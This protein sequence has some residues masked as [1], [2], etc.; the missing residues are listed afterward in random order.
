M[1][2][3]ARAEALGKA[4]NDRALQESA[5]DRGKEL[6]DLKRIAD[7][8]KG[9]FKTLEA[10]PDDPAA[11]AA[12]GKFAALVKG[13][14]KR[15]LPL[16]SKGAEPAWKALADRE[17]APPT[18]AAAQAALGEAWL[19]QAEKETPT[20]KA[21][22]RVRAADWLSRALPGLTGLAKV[23]VEKKLA[24][25]GP[26]AFS[27]DRLLLDLGSGVRIEL[28][29]VKPDAFMRGGNL[30]PQANWEVDE[31][32]EHRVTRT[33]GYH[34]GKYEVTR[35]QFAAFVKAKAYKTDA[36]REG[37]SWGRGTNGEWSAV[38]GLTWQTPNFPQTD[39]H[40]V[41]CVSWNDAK[42]FC[43]W[44]SKKTGR[45]VR[46]PTE[47]EWEFACRAGT[48]T[49]WSFGDDE[50]RVSDYAWTYQNGEF[51]THPVGQKK[52]N[53]WGFFDL[54]GNVCEWCQD[55]AGPYGAEAVD[56][57]GP[58]SGTH[59]LLRGGRWDANP[60][61]SRSSTRG[62]DAPSAR[63]TYSGFRIALY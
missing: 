45:G 15:G 60:Y 53:P 4:A 41:I 10:K 51:Q 39:E 25:L 5:K 12:V 38:A 54:H 17:L 62:M 40:P 16:L 20:Y 48:K 19:A 26:A 1:K 63:N 18:D 44:A 34:L 22:A 61:F 33:R 13:D 56:P 14:W 29:S 2:L 42:A 27:K 59:R 47:A 8:L 49:G 30:P 32:P 7:G 52:P 37:N 43:D 23:A 6:A 9:H 50:G 31:R 57:A 35:G 11:N 36:E 58:S 3:A 21:R 24:A 28:V 55:W 46:L